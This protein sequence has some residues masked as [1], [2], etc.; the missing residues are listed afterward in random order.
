MLKQIQKGSTASISA[1]LLLESEPQ[2]I[3]SAT[4]EIRNPSGSV[5]VP[6]TSTGISGLG[7]SEVTYIRSW[8]SSTFPKD[9]GYK[10]VWLFTVSGVQYSKETFFNVVPRLLVSDL[11]DED[12][13][14]EYPHIEDEAPTTG[15]KAWRIACWEEIVAGI[16]STFQNEEALGRIFNP[17]IFHRSHLYG[18]LH[19][20]YFQN[21]HFTS[22]MNEDWDKSASFGELYKESLGIAM[23]QL[24]ID[25]DDSGLM[26]NE[27][28]EPK[29]VATVEWGR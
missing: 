11:T 14:K 5:L 18:T 2:T 21:A 29:A 28:Q 27:N 25:Y 16:S 10:A 22:T 4:V 1:R 9:V 19:K 12:I 15:L 3:T 7:T 26:D 8:D 23:Q 20:F 6:A 13:F 17:D 24:A